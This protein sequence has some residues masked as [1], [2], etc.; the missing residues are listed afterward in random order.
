MEQSSLVQP[1]SH[2][3]LKLSS[4]LVH[5][6]TASSGILALYAAKAAVEQQMH[7]V[8]YCVVLTVIIDAIDGP[9]ARLVNV[10]KHTPNFDGAMLDNVIDFLTWVFIPAFCLVQSNIFS[11]ETSFFLGTLMILSSSYFYGCSDVKAQHNFFKRFPSAW[12]PIILCVFTWPVS[13]S[14]IFCLIVL[15][16]ILSFV[17][18]YF[19]H[20]LRLDVVF[21]GRKRTDK[22]LSFIMLVSSIC[23]LILLFSSVYFYPEKPY[24]LFAFELLFLFSYLVLTLLQ[25]FVFYKNIRKSR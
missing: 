7:T 22:I 12:S 24:T 1:Q 5:L 14:V 17:P 15:C 11:S 8:L 3:L 21:T 9:L 6:L 4:W 13:P 10:K 19:V 25:N 18:I 23:F 2:F 20:S 16:A